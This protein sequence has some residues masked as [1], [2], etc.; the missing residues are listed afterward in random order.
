MRTEVVTELS[1]M[2]Q[3]V[4]VVAAEVSCYTSGMSIDYLTHWGGELLVWETC[5]V[6]CEVV[7]KQRLQGCESQ[8]LNRS[9]L[10]VQRQVDGY[11]LTV[12]FC[13]GYSEPRQQELR[14]EESGSAV[15]LHQI[16][17]LVEA[18]II[19][20]IVWQ[21]HLGSYQWVGSVCLFAVSPHAVLAVVLNTE[22]RAEAHLEELVQT[23][24]DAGSQ[25]AAAHVGILNQT[26]LLMVVE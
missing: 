2:S 16:T 21:R 22:V 25:G 3:C 7:A 12:L 19:R 4:S 17:S 11:I 5:S 10:L 14:V 6:G 26:I 9:Q 18:I 13:I 23:R 20:C 8:S 15:A 1:C 24:V